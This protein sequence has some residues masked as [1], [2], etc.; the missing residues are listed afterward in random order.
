MDAN[1]A[2]YAL[3]RLHIKPSEWCAMPRRERAF[4]TAC[5]DLK[6]EADKKERT[7]AKRAG[8]RR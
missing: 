1:Y 2:Y 7:K 4:I 5:I 8:K 3:H 6:L